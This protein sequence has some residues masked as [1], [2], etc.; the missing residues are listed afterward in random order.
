MQ[1]PRLG[2]QNSKKNKRSEPVSGTV[3]L[4]GVQVAWSRRLILLYC[5]GIIITELDRKANM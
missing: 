5:H 4:S 3:R 2:K 1:I